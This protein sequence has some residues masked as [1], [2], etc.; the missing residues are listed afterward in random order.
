MTKYRLPFLFLAMP[1]RFISYFKQPFPYIERGWQIIVVSSIW[2]FFVLIIFQP[3]G[4]GSISFNKIWAAFGFSMVT[5]VSTSVVVYIFPLLFKR[6][7]TADGWNKGKFFL[8]CLIIILVITI[9]NVIFDVYMQCSSEKFTIIDLLIHYLFATA[10]I[11]IFPVVVTYFL[12]Q[13]YWLN[14][15]YLEISNLNQLL[16]SQIR[17]IE[18]D[19]EQ[20]GNVTLTGKTR[21]SLSLYLKDL[22][23]IEAS[24]NYVM[25]H[26]YQES[27]IIQK[28]LRSTIQQIEQDLQEYPE[29]VRCHRAF[30]INMI[31]VKEIGSTPQGHY[32]MILEQK[33]KIP[34]S[35]SYKK[36]IR[37]KLSPAVRH[38]PL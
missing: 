20:S 23:Y 37:T 34:V 15:S 10:F 13:N 18:A 36:T 6:F 31:H 3:Y 19:S 28:T 24:G 29:I 27:G 11:G 16:S 2:V 14:K 30:I 7:Y 26:L 32:L 12:I 25:I 8:N 35:R 4:F 38:I 22:L 17:N 9:G 5:A 21:D 1:D 33:I